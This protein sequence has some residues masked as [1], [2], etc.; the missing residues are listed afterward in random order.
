MKNIETITFSNF[1]ENE[2]MILSLNAPPTWN[3]MI[4]ERRI[5][6]YYDAVIEGGSAK[7]LKDYV[8]GLKDKQ[9]NLGS[10]YPNNKSKP[11]EMISVNYF[12][13]N[14]QSSFNTILK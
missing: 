1:P 9:P 6:N 5:L 14:S 8:D 2:K 10:S 12:E 11:T 13:G 7:T 3:N 4:N